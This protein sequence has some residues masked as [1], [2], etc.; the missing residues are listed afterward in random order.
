MGQTGHVTLGASDITFAQPS[1]ALTNTDAT[2]V[3][4]AIEDHDAAIDG[5]ETSIAANIQRGHIWGLTLSN[6]S[7]DATN[8]IDIAV[9][10]A[11]DSAGAYLI[12]LASGLTKRLD[13]SWA[14]GTGNGMLDGSESSAGTPDTSTWYHIFLIRRSDTGTV[15]VLASESAT[16]PTLPTSYDQSRRI[17]A[18]YNNSSGD[19]RAFSQNGDEFLWSSTPTGDVAASPGNTTANLL[20]VSVPTGLKVTALLRGGAVSSAGSPDGRLFVSSPDETDQAAGTTNFNMGWTASTTAVNTQ[21][22][23]IVAI[24]T[25]TSAQIRYRLA[26]SGTSFYLTAFGWIDTRGRLN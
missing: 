13:A 25:N 4:E 19:I 10:E 26:L 15:D 17:G 11:V 3:Q 6:N 16:S 20:V 5:L 24:R 9:G 18:V 8:D 12:E 22:W 2:D 7:T 14:V 1:P 21:N 23:S